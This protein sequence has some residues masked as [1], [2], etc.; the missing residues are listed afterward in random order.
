[1]TDKKIGM[2]CRFLGKYVP[3]HFLYTDDHRRETKCD[4]SGCNNKKCSLCDGFTGDRSKQHDFLDE[5]D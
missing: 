1:M 5:L 2:H 3:V 4:F